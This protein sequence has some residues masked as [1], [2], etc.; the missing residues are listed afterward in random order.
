MS[1]ILLVLCD[2]FRVFHTDSTSK[3]R[4]LVSMS[5]SLV[6]FKRKKRKEKKIKIIWNKR[7]VKEMRISKA[8]CCKVYKASTS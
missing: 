6:W 4:I 7:I 8:K 3:R 2:D 5:Q 1:N